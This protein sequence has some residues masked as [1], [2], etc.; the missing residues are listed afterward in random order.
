[1]ALLLLACA[2]HRLQTRASPFLPVELVEGIWYDYVA[3]RDDLF[4]ACARGQ[5]I[6]IARLF[7]RLDQRLTGV[8][9]LWCACEYGQL[10][11]AQWA[12][13]TFHLTPEDARK[14]DN[15]ALLYACQHGH[16]ELVQWMTL[17]F[18]LTNEDGRADDNDPLQLAC[19]NGHLEM[20]QWI[21]S[22]FQLT[23][24]DA[25]ANGNYALR[26]AC[27]N[28]HLKMVRWITATLHL[29]AEDARDFDN[30]AP[31]LTCE[32]GRLETIKWMT[33]TFQLSIKDA[34]ANDV[35][36]LRL[37]CANGHLEVAQWL[38]ATFHLTAEDARAGDNF[39]LRWACRMG[40]LDVAKWLACTFQLTAE[41][42]GL[43]DF[44]ELRRMCQMGRRDMATWL[45]NVYKL[46]IDDD[47]AACIGGAGQWEAV[48]WSHGDPGAI[49]LANAAAHCL[50]EP[51]TGMQRRH[52]ADEDACPY[53][54]VGIAHSLAIVKDN[55]RWEA[56]VCNAN[57]IEFYATTA[58]EPYFTRR[59]YLVQRI[60]QQ[61]RVQWLRESVR[62]DDYRSVWVTIRR[63]N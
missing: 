13:T 7:Q 54:D 3:T 42:A 21:T 29:T 9:I 20:A 1:M 61:W 38:T 19:E 18:A 49:A 62:A 43:L 27:A 34:R 47:V 57:I 36:A 2:Q 6:V 4:K 44:A 8:D 41:D 35:Y 11:V 23:T 56:H 33:D 50:L 25:R 24:E 55:I 10:K 40:H 63:D 31:Q 5:L 45:V 39:A 58:M 16:L 60:A 52:C 53:P 37:A 17:A 26:S 46:P 48:Q 12:K 28:G 14:F 22:A 32:N 51:L 15:Q 59:I 30:D